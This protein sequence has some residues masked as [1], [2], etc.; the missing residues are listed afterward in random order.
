[1]SHIEPDIPGRLPAA[2][3]TPGLPS[4]TDFLTAYA[5]HLL[6]GVRPLPEGSVPEVP[7]AT[8]I[9]GLSYRGGVVLAGDRRATMVVACGTSGTAP[10]GS[11]RPLGSRCAAYP[12]RNSVKDDVPGVRNAAGSRP[13]TLASMPWLTGRP[14]ARIP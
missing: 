5:G 1:M 9:V 2:F 4:F 7:H 11:A 3:L 8:T 13:G 12:D 6:P 10:A 14:S